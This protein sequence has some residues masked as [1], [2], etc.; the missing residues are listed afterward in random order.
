MRPTT[1]KYFIIIQCDMLL[2]YL[3]LMLLGYIPSRDLV[4]QGHT[5]DLLPLSINY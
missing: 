4:C 3:H 1:F 2:F 5:V